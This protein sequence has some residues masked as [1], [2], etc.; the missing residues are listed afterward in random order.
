MW[1]KPSF[2]RLLRSWHHKVDLRR[3]RALSSSKYGAQ[4]NVNDISAGSPEF[5]NQGR[6]LH[7][8]PGAASKEERQTGDRFLFLGDGNPAPAMK[9]PRNAPSMLA[10]KLEAKII[11]PLKY[12][13]RQNR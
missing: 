8:E 1:L 13:M 9:R 5:S 4:N 3:W 12:P 10:L 7:L 11:S 2:P 6:P